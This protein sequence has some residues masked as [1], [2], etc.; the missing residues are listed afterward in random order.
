[1]DTKHTAAIVSSRNWDDLRQALDGCAQV[2]TLPALDALKALPANECP[3]LALIDFDDVRETLNGA[4]LARNPGTCIVFVSERNEPDA[5]R[6]AMRYGACDFLARPIEPRHIEEI[7]NRASGSLRAAPAPASE[8]SQARD[9]QTFTF[10]TTK[11]GAGK[12]TLLANMAFALAS[13]RPDTR[14]CLLDLDLQFGD[15]AMIF[16]AHPR[17]TIVDAISGGVQPEQAASCLTQIRENISLLASPAKPEEAELIKSHHIEALLRGLQGQFDYILIDTAPS[18][19]D[20]SLAA[21]DRSQKVFLIVTPI[22][23]SVKNLKRVLDVMTNSLGYENDRIEI[24]MNRSDSKFGITRA[25]IEKLCK[26]KVNYQIPSDG[27]LLVQTVN[28]GAPAVCV[29]PRN[30]YSL[31]VTDMARALCGAPEPAPRRRG[32]L[33]LFGKRTAK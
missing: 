27:N 9:T 3:D 25:E 19:H 4:P 17:A 32:L 18:F 20:V 14:V 8:P 29:S 28:A 24:I 5:M 22:I 13:G 10:F 6:L 30:K 15:M 21:L 26:R 11:G 31:A 23:L 1:M 7:L 33:S 16:D 12:S 2:R